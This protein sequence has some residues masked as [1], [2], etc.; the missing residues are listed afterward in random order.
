MGAGPVS[1]KDLLH[2]L[3]LAFFQNENDDL[4]RRV[5][6]TEAEKVLSWN[7]LSVLQVT[8]M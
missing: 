4:R 2:A 8:R 5:A 7:Y 1:A 6:R 3:E